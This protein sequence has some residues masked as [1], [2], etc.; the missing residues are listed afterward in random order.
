MSY[1]IKIVLNIFQQYSFYINSF[2]NRVDIF[3]IYHKREKILNI[4]AVS[5]YEI[6]FIQLSIY[7]IG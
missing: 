7:I 4:Y 5:I 2:K 1:K 6:F 3:D